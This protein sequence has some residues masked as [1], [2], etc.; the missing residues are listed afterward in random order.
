MSSSEYAELARLF[1][2]EV[3]PVKTG[4]RVWMKPTTDGDLQGYQ[5]WRP[6]FQGTRPS[7]SLRRL[8][9]LR[10]AISWFDMVCGLSSIELICSCFE[11]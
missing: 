1:S 9:V 2:Q 8:R 10:W 11:K 7:S 6:P 4:M 3:D 5:I